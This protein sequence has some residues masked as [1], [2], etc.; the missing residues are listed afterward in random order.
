M[1]AALRTSLRHLPSAATPP[2]FGGTWL[3]CIVA[4]VFFQGC[5]EETPPQ[6]LSPPPVVEIEAPPPRTVITREQYDKILYDMRYADVVD[7]LGM[8][9]SRQESTYDEGVEG[10]TGPSVISWYIWDNPDGSF[11]RL[12]FTE[13]RLTDK[14]SHDLSND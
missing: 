4:S 12:G 8:D 2:F 3:C 11:V 7:Y 9:P 6:E 13:K 14:Q 5:A 1:T 10:Y